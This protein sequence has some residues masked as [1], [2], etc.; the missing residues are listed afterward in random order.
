MR[1]PDLTAAISASITNL[2]NDIKQASNK[3]DKVN[4]YQTLRELTGKTIEQELPSV[5]EALSTIL[6]LALYEESKS[7]LNQ[8]ILFIAETM[9]VKGSDSS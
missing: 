3:V 1:R 5:N 4:I 2:V 8:Q 7:S 6:D 9:C